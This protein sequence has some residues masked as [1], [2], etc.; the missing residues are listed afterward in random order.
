MAFGLLAL[1]TAA[2]F[3]AQPRSIVGPEN[4]HLLELSALVPANA[5]ID[6]AWYVRRSGGEP[7]QVLVEWHHYEDVAPKG[8]PPYP[9]LVWRLVLWTP[10]ALR[11]YETR[12]RSRSVVGGPLSLHPIYSVGLADLTGE[13]HPE[14]IVEDYRG[15]H[16]C[17]PRRIVAT[18]GF[19]PRA[20]L[21]DDWCETDWWVRRGTLRIRQAQYA[22]GDSLCCA[23]FERYASYRWNGRR[24][25]VA[26]SRVVRNRLE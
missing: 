17:G 12:W 11:G 20:I 24:L 6:S 26:G 8:G 4:P 25:V 18:I 5:R 10:T 15:N 2:L 16:G 13:G 23:T 22:P 3:A 1:A 19:R 7:P 21:D 14:V 9:N